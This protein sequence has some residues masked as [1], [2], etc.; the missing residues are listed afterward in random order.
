MAKDFFVDSAVALMDNTT[1]TYTAGTATSVAPGD[2]IISRKE[3]YNWRVAAS[4]AT[5][6]HLT[7][8]GGGARLVK[9]YVDAPVVH[10]EMFGKIGTS[11]GD[12]AT[13]AKAMDINRDVEFPGNVYSITEPIQ[14]SNQRI[15]GLG[16]GPGIAR[17]QVLIGVQGDYPCFINKTAGGFNSCEI[18]GFFVNYGESAPSTGVGNANKIG[19]KFTLSPASGVSDGWPELIKISNC[20]VRGAWIAYYDDTGTYGSHLERILALKCRVGFQKVDGTTHAFVNC[21]VAGDGVNSENGFVVTRVPAVS[22]TSCAADL[23]VPG[24]GS[25]GGA[26]IFTSCLGVTINGWDAEGNRIGSGLAYLKVSGSGSLSLRGFVG[27]G[28]TLLGGAGTESFLFLNDGG[29]F[30]FTGLTRLGPDDLK[31]VGVGGNPTTF[32]TVNNG[33]TLLNSSVVHAATGGAPEVAWATRAG[34]GGSAVLLNTKVLGGIRHGAEPLLTQMDVAAMP[35]AGI[36]TKGMFLN[37]TNAAI[38]EGQV[39]PATSLAWSAASGNNIPPNTLP[40]GSQWMCLGTCLANT[41]P[42][43]PRTASTS[44]FIRVS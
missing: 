38:T 39:V 33:Q 2:F 35:L 43:T 10:P 16:K 21:L 3:R 24:S 1:F 13:I 29:Q 31:Y 15:T 44:L 42:P 30:E 34:S 20:T 19:F 36:G 12:S 41:V 27:I 37:T 32:L 28:N 14:V 5:D 26:N 7:T 4:T 6:F 17:A 40:A 23:L 9:L 22:F 25:G 8:A 18:S 11:A